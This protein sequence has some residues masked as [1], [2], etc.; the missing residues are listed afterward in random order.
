MNKT[1]AILTVFGLLML[2][3]GLCAEIILHQA[4]ATAL[5]S[6][7]SIQ[8]A[9]YKIFQRNFSNF[10]AQNKINF[11]KTQGFDHT[12][13]IDTGGFVVF[14]NEIPR[15]VLVYIP[16]KSQ[17]YYN[18]PQIGGL[19]DSDCA[20]TTRLRSSAD[21]FLQE[22]MGEDAK[23][24][25]LSNQELTFKT[26]RDSAPRLFQI[27]FRYV[28]VMDC[29]RI[30]GMACHAIIE[31]GRDCKLAKFTINNPRLEKVKDVD[32]KIK[33]SS[34]SNFLKKYI[35]NRIF[36]KKGDGKDIAIKNTYVTKSWESYFIYKN[37]FPDHLI[38]HMSFLTTDSLSDG[39]A[40]RRQ[41]N[42]P[43]DASIIPNLAGNDII[44]FKKNIKK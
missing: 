12:H 35:E 33:N 19:T 29:R 14:K 39:T 25:S 32:R 16:Q 38:P 5:S 36:H 7:S 3:L 10:D 41:I 23:N 28:R 42:L 31:I 18:N 24:Y 2:P 9:V 44:E 1:I 17:Y 4:A 11:L 26:Q 34:M 43:T 21:R 22:L 6:E 13:K 40:K 20:D 15:N 37:N 30:E 27:G 8:P